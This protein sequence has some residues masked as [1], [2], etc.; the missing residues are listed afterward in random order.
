MS[1]HDQAHSMAGPLIN[2]LNASLQ[3]EYANIVRLPRFRS[4]IEDQEFARKLEWLLTDSLRHAEIVMRHIRRL[5]GEP[6]WTLAPFPEN[7]STID[8]LKRQQNLEQEM[9]GI[10][11]NAMP[12]SDTDELHK[13][14]NGLIAS[15]QNHWA[16][17]DDLIRHPA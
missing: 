16:L 13:D 8:F 2:L 5:G 9:K 3:L 11:E 14:L 6:E 17:C 12:I 10:Y 1:S 15:E 4:S 7:D